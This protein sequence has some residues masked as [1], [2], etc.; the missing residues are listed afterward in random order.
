MIATDPEAPPPTDISKLLNYG[1]DVSQQIC[2][3]DEVM[4][5]A[6]KQQIITGCLG[7]WLLNVSKDLRLVPRKPY[8]PARR[9]PCDRG[10][11]RGWTPPDASQS[12]T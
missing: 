7:I 10:G 1:A 8:F 9:S 3:D 12:L 2:D 6:N 5:L 4:F 11:H